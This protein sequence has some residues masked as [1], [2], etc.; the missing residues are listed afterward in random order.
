M[1][2]RLEFLKCDLVEEVSRALEESICVVKLLVPQRILHTA[3]TPEIA[4]ADVWRSRGMIARCV[5]VLD[6][7]IGK[8]V[9]VILVTSKEEV[10]RDQARASTKECDHRLSA[11]DRLWHI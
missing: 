11:C 7:C 4:E 9:L 6:N 1:E 5:Y 8:T 3:E 10:Q 2:H